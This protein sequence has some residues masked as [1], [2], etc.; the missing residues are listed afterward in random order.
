MKCG[1]FSKERAPSGV[2]SEEAAN[3]SVS[4]NPGTYNLQPTRDR[5]R[6]EEAIARDP[7]SPRQ[8]AMPRSHVGGEEENRYV[9]FL[10]PPPSDCG[11]EGEVSRGCFPLRFRGGWRRRVLCGPSPSAAA[12]RVEGASQRAPPSTTCARGWRGRNQRGP[13]LSPNGVVVQAARSST[14]P[15]YPHSCLPALPGVPGT[16]AHAA[17]VA[18]ALAEVPGH[19]NRHRVPGVRLRLG[20]RFRV[21]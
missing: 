8:F 12:H 4:A 14:P 3:N 1:G 18:E 7:S 16:T 13:S 5:R 6:G 2:G 10:F 17:A 19:R 21:A 15:A 9:P 20:L 11:V